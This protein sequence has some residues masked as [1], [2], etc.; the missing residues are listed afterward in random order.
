MFS[1]TLEWKCNIR[2]R[3]DAEK[4]SMTD[5]C[6]GLAKLAEDNAFIS[7]VFAGSNIFIQHS[8]MKRRGIN[9]IL[10]SLNVP[11]RLHKFM[12]ETITG[13]SESS[14]RSILKLFLYG[15]HNDMR[16]DELEYLKYLDPRD[17]FEC[18]CGE[19]VSSVHV[20]APDSVITVRRFRRPVPRE[21]AAASTDSI[22]ITSTGDVRV[23]ALPFRSVNSSIMI[24]GMSGELVVDIPATTRN[25]S[26]VSNHQGRISISFDMQ[27]IRDIIAGIDMEETDDTNV[28]FDPS[29]IEEDESEEEIDFSTFENVPVLM[30]SRCFS[31]TVEVASSSELNNETCPICL[32]NMTNDNLNMESI[33]VKTKCCGK[34]FHDVCIRHMVCDVG[35]PNCPLCR[36]DLRTMCK[37]E[38]CKHNETDAGNMLEFM[39]IAFEGL[40]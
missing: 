29:Q 17:E 3:L 32:E 16:P 14:E 20:Q 7:P 5:T 35:P 33:A 13:D 4:E 38:E 40:E 27:Y 36:T 8:E 37:R 15:S 1:S 30:Q 28:V 10:Q 23:R 34:I 26:L 39:R 22:N 2:K 6:T 19:C 18:N 21:S 11:K 31:A 12:F 25:S 9:A 24:P